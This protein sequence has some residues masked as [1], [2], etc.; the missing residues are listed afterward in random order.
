MAIAAALTGAF[1]LLAQWLA[2]H[3][4]F[5]YEKQLAS[6]FASAVGAGDE[7]ESYLQ[8]LAGRLAKAEQLPDGMT[9]KLHYR[10]EPVVNAFAT[11][12]GHVVIYRGLLKV[13]PDEN[14]LAMVLAHEIAH[15]KHRHPVTALG[16]GLATAVV[17]STISGAAGNSFAGRAM[18]EAG[19]LTHLGF[20]RAQE[21]QADAT[22]LAAVVALYGHAGGSGELF[23]LMRTASER[24]SE[25]PKLLST[26]PQSEERTARLANLAQTR[27][28]PSEGGRTPLPVA[29][30][31][32]LAAP[33]SQRK[34]DQR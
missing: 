11:L 3:V 28:W 21:E 22:A 6:R 25:P 31:E 4:P 18:G 27:Q 34:Q 13:L 14:S 26:H 5:E 24:A 10:D 1:A 2:P 30:R 33:G 23:K 20:T 8:D 16:R 17:V 32:R 19:L 12:G 29:I 7:V 9:I 15:I